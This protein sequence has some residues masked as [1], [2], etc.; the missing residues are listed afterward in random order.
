MLEVCWEH[1]YSNDMLRLVTD[2]DSK[3][4]EGTA[5]LK[6]KKLIF[7]PCKKNAAKRMMFVRGIGA[8]PSLP[9]GV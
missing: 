4:Y 1:N 8:A 3:L 5:F 2:E 9:H 7:L 6:I